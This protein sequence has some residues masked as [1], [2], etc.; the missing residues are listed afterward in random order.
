MVGLDARTCPDDLVSS[1]LHNRMMQ[2]PQEEEEER[3]PRVIQST[4]KMNQTTSIAAAPRRQLCS[5]RVQSLVKSLGGGSGRA[6]DFSS[7]P[8]RQG[9]LSPQDHLDGLLEQQGYTKTTFRALDTAYYNSPTEMQMA[10]YGRAVIGV[11]RSGNAS[12][13]R[14]YLTHLSSNPCTAKGESI[15]HMICRQGNLSLLK[16][17]VELQQQQ[18]QQQPLSPC[19][20]QT[21]DQYGRTVLHEACWA[22]QPVFE[23]V[24]YL[25]DRNPVLLFLEDSRGASPLSYVH[26]ETW[27][28]WVD[29]L[30]RNVP[31]WFPETPT[32]SFQ[33]GMEL[34]ECNPNSVPLLDKSR[35]QSL[36]EAALIACGQIALIDPNFTPVELISDETIELYDSD[37]SDIEDT[38][39]STDGWDDSSVGAQPSWTPH[40]SEAGNCWGAAMNKMESPLQLDI[41]DSYST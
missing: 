27:S 25:L 11:V 4:T 10:S 3:E 19:L 22:K 15:A 29:F 14:N 34:A 9:K 39:I 17:M 35:C 37:I 8:R 18:Q 2:S 21:V 12:S 20:F 36:E 26:S 6:L 7:G 13:L 5:N 41:R 24:E 32:N 38:S 31:K 16:A 28:L 1:S 40:D 30:E 23:V 33:R